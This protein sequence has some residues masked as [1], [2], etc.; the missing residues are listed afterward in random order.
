MTARP[1]GSASRSSFLSRKSAP[2]F[3]RGGTSRQGSRYSSVLHSQD[4]RPAGWRGRLAA[5]S[6]VTNLGIIILLLFGLGSLFLNFRH[7]TSLTTARLAAPPSSAANPAE[8]SEQ[9]ES[10]KTLAPAPAA[11]M[12]ELD[13][14]V[15]VVGQAV[16]AGRSFEGRKQDSNWVLEEHQ[17]GRT[18]QFWDQIERGIEISNKDA[19]ALLVFSGGQTR[20]HTPQTEAE[21]YLELA[22]QSPM[23]LPVLPGS[24]VVLTTTEKDGAAI[25]QF[26]DAD[27]DGTGEKAG[28]PYGEGVQ[29]SQVAS[30]SAHA[31]AP[32]LTAGNGTGLASLRMTTEGYAL[33]TYQNLVYSIARFRE[34]TNHYPQRIT[35]IDNQLHEKRFKELHTKA[36]RW[37]AQHMYGAHH[38]FNFI[39]FEDKNA[40]T[41][42][43]YRHEA[44]HELALFDKDMYGCHGVLSV[45]CPRRTAHRTALLGVWH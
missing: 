17:K 31:P 32:V 33:D 25:A 27:R 34:V 13:H 5:R 2:G 8:A 19:N 6:R 7:W 3:F 35:V 23:D 15:I 16:W 38:R 40:N 29:V 37:P 14:L 9:T 36:V 44:E 39:G 41:R 18:G 26:L 43:E 20:P 24:K 45:R 4:P 10:V 22:L 42:E 21:S 12:E 28:K 30:S 1:E 11:G